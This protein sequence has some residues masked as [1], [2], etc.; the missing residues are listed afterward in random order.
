[1]EGYEMVLLFLLSGAFGSMWYYTNSFAWE[2]WSFD[3]WVILYF[4]FVVLNQDLKLL[5]NL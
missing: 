3:W 5:T 2:C 1:M 4:V